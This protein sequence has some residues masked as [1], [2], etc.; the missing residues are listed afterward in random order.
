[1]EL[2]LAQG[3]CADR[4]RFFTYLLLEHGTYFVPISYYKYLLAQVNG[5]VTSME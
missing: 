2:G 3:F 5:R 1:M 4:N